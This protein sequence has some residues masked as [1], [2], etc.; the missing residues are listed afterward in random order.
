ML[1]TYLFNHSFYL[2]FSDLGYLG[3]SQ[4]LKITNNAACYIIVHMMVLTFSKF[5]FPPNRHLLWELQQTYLCF[6]VWNDTLHTLDCF[7][8][9]VLELIPAVRSHVP[10]L[11]WKCRRWGRVCVWMWSRGTGAGMKGRALPQ[12]PGL[13][14][15]SSSSRKQPHTGVR[16][17]PAVSEV[18]TLQE[19]LMAKF[20]SP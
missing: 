19:K 13:Y 12:V 3:C 9:L 15:Q 14:T 6:A 4:F 18:P 11:A 17:C 10:A 5:R 7:P 16:L 20:L 8:G 2:R 1:E